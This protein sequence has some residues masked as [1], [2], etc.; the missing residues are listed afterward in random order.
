MSGEEF[1]D[2]S[3]IDFD[4]SVIPE[5]S[6][7]VNAQLTLFANTLNGGHTQ[8]D[9]NNS[10]QLELITEAWNE[11][12]V[13]W[14]N[15]P[16]T[17]EDI[18][19]ELP[20]SQ[21]NDEDYIDIDITELI[22]H[23]HNN[24]NS[25]F[26][27]M[28]KLSDETGRRTLQFGSSDA[29][30]ENLRPILR[31]SFFEPDNCL[32]FNSNN[33]DSRVQSNLPNQNISTTQ[34]FSSQSGTMG[35]DAFIDR[36]IISFN[37]LEQI[38][39]EAIITNASLDLFSN[40]LNGG[41]TQTDGSNSSVLELVT[42]PWNTESVT[43]NNQPDTD[44]NISVILDASESNSQ[45]YMNIDVTSLVESIH[46]N[47]GFGMMIK[48]I[49]ETGRRTMQFASSAASDNT[50]HPKLTVCYRMTTSLN[51]SLLEIDDI[52]IFPNP[53]ND[54]ITIQTNK[55]TLSKIIIY[56]F[57]GVKVSE[58]KVTEKK[59]TINVSRLFQGNYLAVLIKD[60]K[61][62]TRKFMKI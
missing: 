13:T 33:L 38:P 16:K 5:N 30:D 19:I 20:P 1:I 61:V 22:Q 42:E 24:P 53:T 60:D 8:T 58:S 9:G 56:D 37:E 36:S 27:I 62:I 28:I 4:L 57:M 35:G 14:N 7:I 49:D 2:R 17:D 47:N 50:I 10:S 31:I 46:N 12:Q 25:S 52:R 51:E 3:L 15:Q 32:D 59:T 34:F 21:S 48:L 6:L 26:G 40:T 44:P 23:S 29:Q 55:E 43:W 18:S 11:E 39:E 54:L 45:N 41:H